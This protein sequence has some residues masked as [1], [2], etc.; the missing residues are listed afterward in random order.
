MFLHF[1]I[2]IYVTCAAKFGIELQIWP[3]FSPPLLPLLWRLK[4]SF[5]H[6]KIK[7][8][9]CTCLRETCKRQEKHCYIVPFYRISPKFKWVDRA[10]VLSLDV[11]YFHGIPSGV[12]HVPTRPYPLGVWRYLI[13]GGLKYISLMPFFF[14][15]V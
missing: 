9:L 2:V 5:P 3:I 6:L 8:Y 11:C 7:S 10:F 12:R 1:S 14:N 15:N 13:K 4:K